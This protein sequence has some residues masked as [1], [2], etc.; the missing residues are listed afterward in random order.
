MFKV[1]E[2]HGHSLPVKYV[3]EGMDATVSYGYKDFVFQYVGKNPLLL[4]VMAKNGVLDVKF[5]GVGK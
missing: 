3:P 2:R 1:L 5:S 4:S